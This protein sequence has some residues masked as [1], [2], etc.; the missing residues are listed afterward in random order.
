[1]QISSLKELAGMAL[2]QHYVDNWSQM[3]TVTKLGIGALCAPSQPLHD[4][5]GILFGLNE[6]EILPGDV[7]TIKPEGEVSPEHL[8]SSVISVHHILSNTEVVVT[9]YNQRPCYG[10]IVGELPIDDFYTISVGE[11]IIEERYVT[12]IAAVPN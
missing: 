9:M 12:T 3:D 2:V 6:I 4:Y 7:A 11:G 10:V 1:M 8:R 5:S